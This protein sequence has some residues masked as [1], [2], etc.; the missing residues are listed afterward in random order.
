MSIVSLLVGQCG[1][2]VGSEFFKTIYNDNFPELPASSAPS[3]IFFI[4]DSMETFFT[5]GD[6]G[7]IPE[8]RC[9]QI[10]MEEKVVRQI[11][12]EVKRQCAW[13]F[14]KN[15]FCSRSGSGNNWAHGYYLN[16]PP[17][18]E[19]LDVFLRSEF[20]KC[21]LV[22]GLIT[23]MSLAGGTGSGVGTY[24]ITHLK[25]EFSKV[26]ILAQL[27]WPY[28]LGEVVTQ[29][30]NAILSLGHLLRSAGPSGFLLHEN[31]QLHRACAARH[32]S[33]HQSGTSRRLLD[34][35]PLTELNQL[36]GHVLGGLLQPYTDGSSGG[37]WCRRR[38]SRLLFN[39]A[40]P[41]DYRL[42]RLHCLPYHLDKEARRFATETW[43]QLQN[44]GRQLLL[45][46]ACVEDNMNWNI[47]LKNLRGYH[48]Q[49]LLACSGVAR[50]S[51]AP[52]ELAWSELTKDLLNHE[53]TFQPWS[54][55][56]SLG[57][58]NRVFNGHHRGLF[59]ATSGGGLIADPTEPSAVSTDVCA[60]LRSVRSRAWRLF[61][62]SAY[63][64]QYAQYGMEDPRESFLDAF[65]VVEQ[66]IHTYSQLATS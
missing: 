65:A 19:A 37:V 53:S 13:R 46:G 44:H 15:Y 11:D 64:H 3:N 54:E 22:D 31:D 66:T 47:S 49:P 57:V 39:L 1:I 51:G 58:S 5:V 27:V 25:D 38:L 50:G 62:A 56:P 23:T 61:S 29:A 41:R 63:L 45:T 9:I 43:G 20:E 48:W 36:M 60:P 26:P 32:I 16:G 10:D 18:A 7:S 52:G 17:C 33:K 21:D 30:Y 40:G 59:L 8:A 42:Y 2:Q 4:N 34:Q 55:S 24:L 12:S 6:E 35:V 14:S 28:R